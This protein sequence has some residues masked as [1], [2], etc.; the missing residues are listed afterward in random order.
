MGLCIWRC[1]GNWCLLWH[2]HLISCPV[3]VQGVWNKTLRFS[4]ISLTLSNYMN[5]LKWEHSHLAFFVQLL[6]SSPGQAG[7]HPG[8]SHTSVS[9]QLYELRGQVGSSLAQPVKW[10]K[11]CGR[12]A[13]LRVGFSVN[14]KGLCWVWLWL[15][16][17]CPLSHSVNYPSINL[18]GL[19]KGQGDHSTMT[20]TDK[21]DLT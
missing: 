19:Y 1:W 16:T 13:R 6:E 21:T 12:E 15:T 7:S 9:Q 11:T 5:H 3:K 14:S 20:V 8:E 18:K 4:L 17:R 10:L 2:L